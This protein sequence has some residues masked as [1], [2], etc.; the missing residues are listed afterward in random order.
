LLLACL[1]DEAACLLR[2]I[3]HQSW[4]VVLNCPCCHTARLR[5][6]VCCPMCQAQLAA[7]GCKSSWADVAADVIVSC[8]KSV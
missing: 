6:P 8:D 1:Q 7:A 5:E 2:V 3:L 4:N